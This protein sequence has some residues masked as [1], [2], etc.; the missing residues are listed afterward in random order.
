MTNTLFFIFLLFAAIANCFVVMAFA[1]YIVK[2][3]SEADEQQRLEEQRRL[4][5]R[6]NLYDKRPIYKL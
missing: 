6:G 2:N 3:E 5:Y 1:D 4:Q